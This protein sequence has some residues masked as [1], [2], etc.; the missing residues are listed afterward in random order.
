LVNCPIFPI[1]MGNHNI[2][3]SKIDSLGVNMWISI[4]IT[5][6]HN[7][8]LTCHSI[9]TVLVTLILITLFRNARSSKPMKL[10]S[11]KALHTRIECWKGKD[12][13][14]I[15]LAN[16][17]ITHMHRPNSNRPKNKISWMYRFKKVSSFQRQPY[18][19]Q[20][21]PSGGNF[22]A[23]LQPSQQETP[24]LPWNFNSKWNLSKAHKCEILTTS[25]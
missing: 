23:S 13:N 11:N 8:M 17:K 1:V 20:L 4:T 21:W 16:T 3:Q 2:L 12:T 24:Q 7:M 14:A 10:Y 25:M 5:N 19:K 18:P 6:I 22:V 9:S 15:L